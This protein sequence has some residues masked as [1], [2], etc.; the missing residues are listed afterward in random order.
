MHSPTK[1]HPIFIILTFDSTESFTFLHVLLFASIN[2]KL[3]IFVECDGEKGIGN[4]FFGM[5]EIDR[6]NMSWWRTF[7][8][9]TLLS[10]WLHMQFSNQFKFVFFLFFFIWYRIES[11]RNFLLL[12]LLFVQVRVLSYNYISREWIFYSEYKMCAALQFMCGLCFCCI[13]EKEKI[14]YKLRT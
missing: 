5:R 1:L 10:T 6:M 7:S 2:L 13:G 11:N 4:V 14:V 12:F 8:A 3:G 9:V